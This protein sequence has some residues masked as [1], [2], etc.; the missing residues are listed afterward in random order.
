MAPFPPHPH[1][2][3]CPTFAEFFKD[4]QNLD[5][6]TEGFFFTVDDT[7]KDFFIYYCPFCG[8]KL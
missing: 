1:L 7:G 6:G 2:A 3:V 5:R 8:G 4:F